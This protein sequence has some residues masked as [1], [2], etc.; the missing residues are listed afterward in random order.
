MLPDLAREQVQLALSDKQ[1]AA[2]LSNPG[3]GAGA[4]PVSAPT[5]SIAPLPAVAED[6]EREHGADDAKEGEGGADGGGAVAVAV[7]AELRVKVKGLRDELFSFRRDL[8]LQG[9][10]LQGLKDDCMERSVKQS[11]SEVRTLFQGLRCSGIS[12]GGTKESIY[13]YE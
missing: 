7:A 1:P 6:D 4:H 3:K 11:E 8:S 10:E 5:S 9:T 13:K 12:T 2:T